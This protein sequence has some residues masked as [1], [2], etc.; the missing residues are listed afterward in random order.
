MIVFLN[1]RSLEQH[2]N[3]SLAL[4]LFWQA[5]LELS[6]ISAEVFRDSYFFFGANF[7]QRVGLALS[8][9][10]PELRPILLQVAFSERYYK[11]WRPGRDSVTN[12]T[13]SCVDPAVSMQDE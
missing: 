1:E 12:E 8:A 9:V 13:Y 2:S 7:K 5:A 11:C 10:S 4:K 6:G 3:G